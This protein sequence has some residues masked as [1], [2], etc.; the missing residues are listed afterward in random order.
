MLHLR[1]VKTNVV[2]STTFG[3]TTSNRRYPLL[4]YC[5]K[6]VLE[7]GRGGRDVDRR[8]DHH[9][10]A[11]DRDRWIGH[12]ICARQG[13]IHRLTWSA[14]VRADP[15]Q[16][17]CRR[18]RWRNN[19]ERPRVAVANGDLT[20]T[21]SRRRADGQCRRHSC[22]RYGHVNHADAIATHDDRI[23]GRAC[24]RHKIRSVNVTITK[25]LGLPKF[26]LILF[27]AGAETNLRHCGITPA[28]Q[29]NKCGQHGPRCRLREILANRHASGL[30]PPPLWQSIRQTGRTHDLNR[31]DTVLTGFDLQEMSITPL[32]LQSSLWESFAI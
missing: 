28:T 2:T 30:L 5:V 15:A 3:G 25:E 14:E 18:R 7:R 19:R 17:R 8:T 10:A 31:L 13:H 16:N 12:K 20:I 6:P 9:G 24:R 32:P 26:G 29:H 21:Q 22:R 27:S 1:K 4:V 11:I 23:G